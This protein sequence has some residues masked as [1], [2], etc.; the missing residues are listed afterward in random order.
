MKG[1]KQHSGKESAQQPLALDQLTNCLWASSQFSWGPL[2]CSSV[3][4]AQVAMPASDKEVTGDPALELQ[5]VGFPRLGSL[6]AE[7]PLAWPQEE[8]INMHSQRPPR[9]LAG[10]RGMKGEE[11]IWETRPVV[12]PPALVLRDV[13]LGDASALF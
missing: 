8:E 6:S 9:E 3:K 13:L 7:L 2:F 4:W 11:G 1:W 10:H 5:A 12:Q